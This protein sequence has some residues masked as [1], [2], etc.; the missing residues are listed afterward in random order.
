MKN[1]RLAVKLGAS[2][3]M[4][5]LITFILGGVAYLNMNKVQI[6]SEKLAKE[7]APEVNYANQIERNALMAM[8]NMRGY[9]Y[10]TEDQFLKD[11]YSFLDKVSESLK[12]ARKLADGAKYVVKLKDAVDEVESSLNNYRKLSDETVKANVLITQNKMDLDAGAKNYMTNCADFLKSQEEAM[13]E[14]ISKGLSAEKLNERIKKIALV[15][16]IIDIGQNIRV[17]TWKAQADRNIQEIKDI[18]PEFKAV[19]E[20]F[21]DLRK[22]TRL[23]ANINQINN[24]EKAAKR[25]EAAMV[26]L[27]E[28]WEYVDE[29]GEKRLIESMVVLNKSKDVSTAGIEH[30]LRISDDAVTLLNTSN[31]ILVIGLIIALVIG[32]IL[33][34][35]VTRMISKPVMLGV[36]FAKEVAAGNLDATIDLNQKDEVGQL[37]NALK[38]M[39]AKLRSIVIDVKSASDNVTAGS[40]ELNSAAQDMSQGATEQ[41]AAAE[42]AS[43]SME[44][45]ASNINQNADNALQTEKIALKAAEDAKNG[46]DAVDKTV[47]AMKDI[48]GKISIIEEIARQTNLLALNA[49]IEAARAGEHGKG[50]AVVASEVRKLA[51]RSQEAAGEIGELSSSSVEIAEKAGSL[52]QQILP[53]IQ[54]TAELVQ[55]IT[56]SSS[57]QRTGADQIN[58]AIQQLD[59]VIQRNAGAS[60]EMASTAE[61]LSSQAEA[62]QHAMSY[63]RM[64][65]SGTSKFSSKGKKNLSNKGIK[66]VSGHVVKKGNSSKGV[67]LDMNDGGALD[68]LDDDFVSY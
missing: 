65:D 39:I 33:A 13:K 47:K 63:F 57:E 14:D 6:E 9:A 40:G 49:A 58:K 64:A 62:L 27:L 34:F 46:G 12:E 2:F 20:L 25:Y 55:E 30:T 61:E 29:L 22:I 5:L 38:D 4:I 32:I 21:E 18:L 37:A 56:A 36:E 1:L 43:S 24:T 19:G 68:K 10:T 11:G 35:L 3:G 17:A 41:A 52:L 50:F 7:Y 15:T 53:D 44:Q 45:M 51:E 8:F 48:A 16:Q 23:K 26:S 31:H 66:A 42:E 67:N 59:Q 28:N 60:E 54:K